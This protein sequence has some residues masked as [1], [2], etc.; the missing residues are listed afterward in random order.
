M[1]K[2][3]ANSPSKTI[4]QLWVEDVER[5]YDTMLAD[6]NAEIIRMR[7]LGMSNEEIFN[8]LQTN[9]DENLTVFQSFDGWVKGATEKLATGV[10]QQEAH[11]QLN[12]PGRL[13]SWELDPTAEHCDD[14]LSNAKMSPQS[15]QEWAMIGLPGV[16]NT[17]CGSFCKC[18]LQEAA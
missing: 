6:V 5:A 9:F 12:I 10:A 13:Y 1:A 14:C 15:F 2:L 16:G 8:R 7:A 4:F 11:N 18:A 3:G 17:Q